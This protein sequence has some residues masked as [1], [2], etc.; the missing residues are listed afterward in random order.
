MLDNLMAV[1]EKIVILGGE[2]EELANEVEESA[3]L[4]TKYY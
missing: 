1:F 2:S 3:L 4:I